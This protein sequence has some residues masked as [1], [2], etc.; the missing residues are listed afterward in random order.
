MPMMGVSKREDPPMPASK[1]S[2]HT[3][4]YRVANH[5]AYLSI[6]DENPWLDRR[7]RL[8]PAGPLQ[9]RL[10]LAGFSPRDAQS[11]WRRW[12]LPFRW[13]RTRHHPVSA[14]GRG[15]RSPSAR[16]ETGVSIDRRQKA[17]P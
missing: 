3:V 12:R 11:S 6:T 15:G 13:L 1:L 9:I 17:L 4:L 5:A 2:I 16:S 8:L 14:S 10:Q 7:G